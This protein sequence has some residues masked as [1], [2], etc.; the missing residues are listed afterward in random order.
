MFSRP[1][2]LTKEPLRSVD[3]IGKTD[4]KKL[5]KHD[6]RTTEELEPRKSLCTDVV[7]KHLDHIDVCQG[8]VT[9]AVSLV[10]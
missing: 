9:D 4:R 5:T 8:V 2:G 10:S 1:M 6:G 3:R 7:G